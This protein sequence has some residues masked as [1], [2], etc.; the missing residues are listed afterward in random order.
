MI[1][2]DKIID[3]RKKN[4]WSQEDLAEK[5]R[6]SRQ[7]V[8]KWEGAQSTP[9][10]QRILEM[11]RLFGVSTD[12]LLKDDLDDSNEV[13]TESKEE[14]DDPIRRVDMETASQF[15]SFRRCWA[16]KIAF[17]TF[18]CIISPV[19]LMLLGAFSEYGELG[20]SENAVAGLG[21]IILLLFVA[22]AVS[23]F[24]PYGIKNQAYEFLEKENIDT[25]YGV[26]GMARECRDRYA[27]IYSGYIILGVVLC[28]LSVVPLFASLCA[29]E[30][31]LA[32]IIS[33]CALLVIVGIGVIFL[34][35]AGMN[36]G[37]ANMLLQEGDYT[38]MEK[39]KNRLTA[40]AATVYWLLVTAGYL[41]WS[42]TTTGWNRTW[43]VW[44][45]AGVLFPAIMAIVGAIRSRNDDE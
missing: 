28:I 19:A 30:S 39:Q 36:R 4:G 24:I 45:A 6:V 44:P 43:I 7:A 10:I 29:T 33:V 15:I 21:I 20:I 26:T 18:L 32:L 2:A 34:I 11:S 17:A 42:F 37:A 3:L 16:P 1:L 38:R 9:D 41:A 8:S 40:T 22:G 13:L 5:L 35:I 31:G 23:I 27:G 25:A 12:F 14:K